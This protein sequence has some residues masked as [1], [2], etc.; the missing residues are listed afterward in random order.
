MLN[1][2]RFDPEVAGRQEL[3]VVE[4]GLRQ[5][6]KELMEARQ[7]LEAE[8]LRYQ[9]LFEFAPDA[10]LVTDLQGAVQEA[11]QAAASLLGV[12]RDALMR[13]SI[14][15]YVPPSDL[16][17]LDRHL[18][19]LRA[20]EVGVPGRWEMRLQIDEDTVLDAAVTV[21]AMQSGPCVEE[22]CTL[23]WLI[24][25]VSERKEAE[26]ALQAALAE[27][28]EGRRTLDALMECLPEGITL[29][30]GQDMKLTRV[31][32]HGQELLGGP[33]AGQSIADVLALWKVYEPDGTTPMAPEDTPLARAIRHGEVVQGRELVQETASGGRVWL[34]CNAGPIR[35]AAGEITGGI[36]A[37][38]DVTE[39]RRAEESVRHLAQFP[40]ESPD[41]VLRLTGDGQL[42]YANEPGHKWFASMDGVEG[43]PLPEA[44][45][46]LVSQACQQGQ[47]VRAE[48]D[49]D[50]GRTFWLA[51]VQPE[52]E[53]YVNLY[54]RDISDRKQAED[55]LRESEAK[56]QALFEIL[57]VG[58]SILD[59]ERRVRYSN[60][61]LARILDLHGEDLVQGRYPQRTYLHP[62]GRPMA[63]A[64]LP[65]VRAFA[66]QQT[67]RDVEVGVVKEDG[68]LIWTNVSAV[69]LA[70][71]DWSVILVTADVTE[72]VQARQ[73]IAEQAALLDT[74]LASIADAVA[75]YGLDT[76]I[77][78]TNAAAD[79]LF[80]YKRGEPIRSLAERAAETRPRREDDRP[81]TLEELPVMRA[82][83]GETVTGVVTALDLGPEPTWMLVSAAPVRN[84]GGD[85][86]G[87]I[88]SFTDIT[89]LRHAREELEKRV[90]ERTA[91]LVIMNEVLQDEIGARRQSEAELRESEL[92]FRQLAEN[93]EE[94]FWLAEPEEDR[95]L[96]L[97]PA[98]QT[99]WGR[100][101]GDAYEHSQLVLKDVHPQDFERLRAL[102]HGASTE[103]QEFRIVLPDGTVRWLRG[104]AFPIEVE[105][106]AARRIAGLISDVTAE[107]EALAALIHAE[108]LSTAGRMAASLAHEINNPLQSAIGCVDLAR[109]DLEA[110]KDPAHF[111]VVVSE[112]LARAARV[113][114]H[115]RA[116]GHQ[117]RQE[118]RK[119]GDLKEA[120]EKV[121]LLTQKSCEVKRVTVVREMKEDLPV[122]RLMNDGIQQVFLNLVLNA[123]DAMPLGGT[124]RVSVEASEQPLGVWVRIADT[125]AGI[126]AADMNHLFE[127]FR[128]TKTQGLGLGLFIC[129]N[130]V[131]Q[132][133]GRIE[134]DSK[135]GQ[136]TEVSVWL[137]A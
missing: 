10:Y 52:G 31:S 81:Y 131:A 129:H 126:P 101:L 46:A 132:H 79:A 16:A 72:K 19:G 65:S 78:R 93:I 53:P 74:M 107:K 83:R 62:D 58:I 100:P 82:L 43:E 117:W 18:A 15:H 127:P 96:Y 135:E 48:L 23:R 91:E 49:N 136:G 122:V 92:R 103:Q 39:Q 60:P 67:V 88:V 137:P 102:W 57:P 11:N 22:E 42:L 26:R 29:S 9:E 37:W 25:D 116:M 77:L 1:P 2:E 41:A 99:V 97:S 55:A 95:L 108:R 17:E 90:Q 14:R 50:A 105:P 32:R 94:V 34:S 119:P 118:E 35:N 38:R 28:E 124:L 86:L 69:P 5:Q 113:V 27:A 44:L 75:F 114:G 66:E 85:L 56:R 45:Q 98:Y 40:I 121:L 8:R 68:A 59:A 115:L 20:R 54:A 3:E 120:I 123:L 61:A 128:T 109:E 87:A 89:E 33:H 84:A 130:I 133:Q 111:L 63:A 112:A 47:V 30:L 21:A 106:G 36:V 134:I 6:N 4:E 80:G 24:R 70:F 73:Q 110:G 76:K 71:D 13:R 7:A 64:E 104:R 12:S 125:G 51:L